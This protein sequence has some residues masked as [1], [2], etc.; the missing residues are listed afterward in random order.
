MKSRAAEEVLVTWGERQGHWW[1]RRSPHYLG[2]RGQEHFLLLV[3]RVL[4]TTLRE[5]LLASIRATPQKKQQLCLATAASF[6]ARDSTINQLLESG[7]L[8]S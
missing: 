5:P 7:L 2:L 3:E 4:F 6:T 8:W 1:Q